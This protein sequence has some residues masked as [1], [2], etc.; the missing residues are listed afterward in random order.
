MSNAAGQIEISTIPTGAW[1]VGVSGGADSVA[2]LMLLSRFPGLQLHVA[3]LDHELRGLESRGDAAF[4]RKL[5]QRLNLPVTIARRSEIEPNLTNL[6]A[7]PS[8]KYRALRMESFRRVVAENHLQG[9]ILAHH[10]N[11][12][13]ETVLQRL[14]RGSGVAGLGGIEPDCMVEGLRI[15][16]PMLNVCRNRLRRFLNDQNQPWREDASNS[17]DDYLRNRLRKILQ[18]RPKLS[19]SLL[20]LATASRNL[21]QWCLSNAPNLP[22]TFATRRLENLPPILARQAARKW[23]IAAGSPPEELSPSVLDRLTAMAA[24]AATPARQQFPGEVTAHRKSGKIATDL[25]ADFHR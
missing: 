8:A 21:N 22:E 6:P 1:A 18:S 4:V 13:A 3:H 7:N 9:V 5:A 2:L 11:D 17:K 15:L 14:I 23:L 25:K 10:A 24:D 20:E 16:R 12:V 19:Q